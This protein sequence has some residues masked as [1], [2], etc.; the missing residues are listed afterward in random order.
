MAEALHEQPIS[1]CFSTAFGLAMT[2]FCILDPQMISGERGQRY[3]GTHKLQVDPQPC[4][5]IHKS[6]DL[7]LI[8]ILKF[9]H[10]FHKTPKALL[11]Q[12]THLNED[13]HIHP[14]A[15]L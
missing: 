1:T 8:F 13:L 5:Q 2:E 14:Y 7:F 9:V 10:H 6:D 12:T 11:E 3:H 15:S 4:M